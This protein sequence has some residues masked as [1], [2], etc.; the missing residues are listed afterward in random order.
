MSNSI[1]MHDPICWES[2]T[3]SKLCWKMVW[4]V[5]HV[6]EMNILPCAPGKLCQSCRTEACWGLKGLFMQHHSKSCSTD[7]K[8]LFIS[9][10]K[11]HILCQLMQPQALGGSPMC[12]PH[13]QPVVFASTEQHRYTDEEIGCFWQVYCAWKSYKA[14][15]LICIDKGTCWQRE[16][17]LLDLSS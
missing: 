4:G 17:R 1:G 6:M 13:L 16:W 8:N 14:L 10:H 11:E 9:S 15:N 12:L 3:W 5:C 2:S 7:G